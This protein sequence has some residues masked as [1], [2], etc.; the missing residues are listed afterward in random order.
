MKHVTRLLTISAVIA[1]AAI[2]LSVRL[3]AV[4]LLPIDYDEDDYLAVAQRYAQLVAAGDMRGIVDYGFNYEHPPLTKLAYGLAILPLPAAPLIPEQTSPNIPPARSL[5]QPQFRVART[6]S[7]ALGT[8]EVLALAVISPLAGLFLAANTWTIKYT[9]QIMLEPL[10]TLTS[11]LA[12]LF[13]FRAKRNPVSGRNGFPSWLVLSAVALGL[14]AASK[15][16]Y[17]IVGLAILADSIWQM[18]DG[19]WRTADGPGGHRP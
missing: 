13:Y 9:S 5:P 14:T 8:L 3:R 12:V 11:M 7:A 17:C 18:A 16:T 1:V 19:R 4:R 6:L 2:A 15:Y 10:P